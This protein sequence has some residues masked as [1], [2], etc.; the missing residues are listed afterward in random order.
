MGFQVTE[1]KPTVAELELKLANSKVTKVRLDILNS[2]MRDY[3]GEIEGHFQTVVKEP[4]NVI[5][6]YKVPHQKE[7]VEKIVKAIES[8]VAGKYTLREKV[9]CKVAHGNNLEFE[10]LLNLDKISEVASARKKLTSADS[11]KQSKQDKLKK[12]Y[13]NQLFNISNGKEFDIF[14]VDS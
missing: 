12:W 7:D 8:V 6:D 10:L 1:K 11:E 2:I 14:E 9:V 4:K 5:N 3:Y 13:R